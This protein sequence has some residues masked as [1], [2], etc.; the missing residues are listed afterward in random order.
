MTRRELISEVVEY[1]E[2][3]YSTTRRHSTLSY[4]SPA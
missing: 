4:L 1:V 2:G 3:V